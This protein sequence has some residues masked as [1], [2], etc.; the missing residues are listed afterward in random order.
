MNIVFSCIH[1]P[2]TDTQ[3]NESTYIIIYTSNI[4]IN[5]E[6]KRYYRNS[7][8]QAPSTDH[9]TSSTTEAIELSLTGPKQRQGRRS[10]QNTGLHKS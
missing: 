9:E 7:G 10:Q 3:T 8:I 6:E 1:T 2:L 5:N 4:S